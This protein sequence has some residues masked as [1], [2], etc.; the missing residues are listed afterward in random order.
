MIIT[1]KTRD[2]KYANHFGMKI[3]LLYL[4]QNVHIDVPLY[5]FHLFIF[6]ILLSF[7]SIL[8][9]NSLIRRE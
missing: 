6:L 3:V 8:S 9:L 4:T 5:K 7:F 1:E 2:E